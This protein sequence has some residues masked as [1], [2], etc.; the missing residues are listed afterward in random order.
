MKARSCLSGLLCILADIVPEAR[1]ECPT[2]DFDGLPVGTVVTTQYAGVRFS[3]RDPDGTS[4]VN[5]I[6]YNPSGGTTSEP[7]CLS[8]RGDGLN[9]FSS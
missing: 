3:G 1:A 7:Q 2:I 6:V 9:E 8:A 5:P 4:G